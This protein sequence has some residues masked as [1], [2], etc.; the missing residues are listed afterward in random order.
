MS[1]TIIFLI[2]VITV[3]A[4]VQ[5]EDRLR[6]ETTIIKGNKEMPQILYVVPWQDMKQSGPKDQTLVLHSLYGNIFDPVGAEA[7]TVNRTQT[8][9]LSQSK[10]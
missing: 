1:R 4:P 3:L 7:E 8:G 9:K 5:A 10:P 2:S 6:L